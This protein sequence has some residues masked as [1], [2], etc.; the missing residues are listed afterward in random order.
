MWDVG[1]RRIDGGVERGEDFARP[2]ESAFFDGLESGEV[3]E[4]QDQ[5]SGDEARIHEHGE[6]GVHAAG[7]LLED[8]A[9]IAQERE[10]AELARGDEFVPS[11]AFQAG[12]RLG[13]GAL[14]D[15]RSC[16]GQSCFPSIGGNKLAAH[17]LPQRLGVGRV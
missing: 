17:E 5:R 7:G 4:G 10:V 11:H 6:G 1:E 2:G 8:V 12:D 15:L 16:L 9:Q 13:A 14:A 3:A